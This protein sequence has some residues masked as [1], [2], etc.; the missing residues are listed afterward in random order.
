MLEAA[1]KKEIVPELQGIADD[2]LKEPT[3]FVD[4]LREKATFIQT[5][6]TTCMEEVENS[7]HRFGE[8]LSD[9][10]KKALTAFLATL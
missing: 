10:D 6:Y 2:I 5:H 1:G 7:G 3:H 9:A 4:V 8:D